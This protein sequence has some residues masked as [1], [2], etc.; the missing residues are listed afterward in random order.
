MTACYVVN[1]TALDSGGGLSILQQFIENIPSDDQNW[2]IFV[3]PEISVQSKNPNVLIEPIYGVKSLAKRLYWDAFGLKRWLKKHD[4]DPV[5]YEYIDEAGNIT[6]K[7][8]ADVAAGTVAP[9]GKQLEPMAEGVTLLIN[10]IFDPNLLKEMTGD[11]NKTK[12]PEPRL[13][14]NF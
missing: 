5:A 1:A 3:S 12:L 14:A 8:H 2:L 11:D 13:N 10:S 9:Y 4:I 7:Y 6:P